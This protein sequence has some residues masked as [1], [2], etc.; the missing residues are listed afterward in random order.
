MLVEKEIAADA[1]QD[2]CSGG[3]ESE[4]TDNHQ[5]KFGCPHCGQQ[6]DVVW[7]GEGADRRL[8]RLSIGFHIEDGRVPGARHVIICNVCDEIDP[9]RIAT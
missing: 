4:M 3:N 8:V 5:I 7:N 2:R 9:A 6:G 1:R